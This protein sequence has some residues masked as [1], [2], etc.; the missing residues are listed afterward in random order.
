MRRP[1]Y[2]ELICSAEGEGI[3]GSSG[4]L[5]PHGLL[6]EVL[7]DRVHAVLAAEPGM[8][9]S[10]EWHRGRD[11]AVGVDP[12][13]ASP[14]AGGDP[15]GSVHVLRPHCGGQTVGGIVGELD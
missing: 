5:D 13:I 8:L 6:L 12:H 11:D 4:E 2:S 7:V 9:E 10:A 14:N 1:F 3:A 15:V